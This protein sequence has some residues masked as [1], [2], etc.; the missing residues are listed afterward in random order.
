MTRRS[1]SSPLAFKQALE[2]RLRTETSSGAGWARKRQLL[3]F[4]RFLARVFAELGDVQTRQSS[5]HQ[6]R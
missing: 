3:V 5:D 6:R 4:D 1:Y 2:E